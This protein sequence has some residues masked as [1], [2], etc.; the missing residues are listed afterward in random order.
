MPDGYRIVRLGPHDRT[1]FN[2]GVEALDQYLRERASQ[3]VR[4]RI[5]NCFV[6]LDSNE[7][8]AG[9][10]T[11]AAADIPMTDLPAEAAK[12]LPRYQ[13][14][15]AALIGRLAVD[16]QFQGQRLGEALVADATLRAQ[17]AAPAIFALVVDAKD[18]GAA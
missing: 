1:R 13:T 15:P 3:D 14:L 2:C 18:E 8:I 17:Q 12:H 7:T 5:S 16:R 10:Y 6:A 11:F 9:Y 4:R